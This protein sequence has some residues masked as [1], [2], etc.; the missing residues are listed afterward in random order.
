MKFD[1]NDRVIITTTSSRQT[2][3]SGTI[4]HAHEGNNVEN[5]YVVAVDG[6]GEVGYFEHEIE[7]V[8]SK[9]TKSLIALAE[10]FEAARILANDIESAAHTH[11]PYGYASQGLWHTLHAILGGSKDETEA[12]YSAIVFDGMTVPQGIKHVKGY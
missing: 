12:C 8:E 5:S 10:S 1:L 6:Y 9:E 7:L 11:G 3:K 2:G 4:I